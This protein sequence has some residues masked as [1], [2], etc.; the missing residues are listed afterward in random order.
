M[1][2]AVNEIIEG[3]VKHHSMTTGG[4]KFW[5]KLQV[6]TL[7]EYKCRLCVVEQENLANFEP[8]KVGFEFDVTLDTINDP[9][10]FRKVPNV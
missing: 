8:F 5:L 1:K 3:F 9:K 2:I 6:L 10:W 4:T 7:N